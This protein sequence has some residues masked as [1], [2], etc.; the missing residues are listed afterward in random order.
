MKYISVKDV[1]MMFDVSQQTI[2]NWIRNNHL[3]CKTG[4]GGRKYILESSCD[5][6]IQDSF[7]MQG[8]KRSEKQTNLSEDNST[9]PENSMQLQEVQTVLEKV[10]QNQQT[11]LQEIADIK[12]RMATKEG[13]KR[14]TDYVQERIKAVEDM[15]E[16]NSAPLQ[17]DSTL[18]QLE[19]SLNSEVKYKKDT[20]FVK[21]ARRYIEEAIKEGCPKSHIDEKGNGSDLIKWLNGSRPGVRETTIKKW[22]DKARELCG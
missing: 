5:K 3:E 2:H 20:E 14:E 13:V 21:E 16:V 22:Y 15:I 9:K 4:K 11:L 8:I 1:A 18:I 6:L 7:F 12:K 19:S 10:L 17:V